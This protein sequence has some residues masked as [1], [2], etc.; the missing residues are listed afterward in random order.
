MNWSDYIGIYPLNT[1]IIYRS[2]KNSA[3]QPIA[4]VSANVHSY[5]DLDPPSGSNRYFIGIKGNNNCIDSNKM[6]I[7]NTVAFGML[8]TEN[9][10]N[11]ISIFP[12]PTNSTIQLINAPLNASIKILNIEGQVVKT[13]TNNT[14]N[15]NINIESLSNGIYFIKINNLKPIKLV[16][17]N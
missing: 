14:N 7:S 12:N 5:S 13:Y 9:L 16:K 8:S 11:E 2:N 15:Q 1:Y 3:F 4:S 10:T 6:V 17:I